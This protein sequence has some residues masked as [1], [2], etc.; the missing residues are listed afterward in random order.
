MKKIIAAT[1]ALF[2]AS[3]IFA[4]GIEN[5][6][7]MSTGYLRNPSRNTE[8][9]RPEASF[10]NIAGTAFMEDG[11]YIE[12]GNQFVVKEYANTL[13]TNILSAAGINDGTKYNDETFVYLYPN[14]DVV[15]KHG[16][17]SIF[18]NFGIY[19]GGGKLE[20]SEGT[21]ATALLFGGAGSVYKAQAEAYGAKAQA[22]AAEGNTASAVSYQTAANTA[23]KN[24]LTFFGAAASHSLTV[25]SI[26][27][28]EQIG[29][30]WNFNDLVS[31]AAAVRFLQGTQDMKI[32][33][34][35]F[36]AAENGSDEISYSAKAFGISPV[37]GVHAKPLD[38]L[39]VAVQFQMKTKMNYDVSDVKGNLASS[40][41]GITNDSEFRTDLSHALNLGVGYQVL[42][43]LYVSTSCNIYFNKDSKMDNILAESDYD[44][45]Y[46]FA[47]GA[48]WKFNEKVLASLGFGYAKQGTADDS[49]NTFNP[50]LDSFQIGAGAEVS[51]V[52]DLTLIGGVTYVK[53]FDT[54]YY[55][56]GTYKTE[57]SKSVFMFS[58]GASYKLPM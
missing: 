36:E 20:Y 29:L 12:A 55:L 41:A 56:N 2:S 9:E 1:T 8:C 51:P 34:S 3:M 33:S 11:L 46:E 32:T 58:V 54:D 25:N 30:G 7:N 44:N 17:F 31:V 4:G 26:T 10:Y 16:P 27:Y 35:Y 53:Y 43:P 19:A 45:S 15:Y 50:V 47:L 24:A 6:T 38:G 37:F 21:S 5:K 48:D 23:T 28:G 40:V 13:A 42:E 22:A 14:V 18:A 52:E 49:N 57:L 39:D